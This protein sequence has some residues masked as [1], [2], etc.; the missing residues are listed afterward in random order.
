MENN[1]ST[2]KTTKQEEKPVEMNEKAYGIAKDE[3]G[4]WHHFI[5]NFNAKT[6]HA[7]VESS[8]K[9]GGKSSAVERFKITVGQSGMLD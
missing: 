8:T 7:K 1:V 4:Y 2:K 5:L 3:E 6:G 9:E